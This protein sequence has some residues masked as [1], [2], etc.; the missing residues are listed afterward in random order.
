MSS[1]VVAAALFV[2]SLLPSMAAP[3]ADDVLGAEPA[4]VSYLPLDTDILNP[5]R[6]L[7]VQVDLVNETNL[8]WVREQGSVIAFAY[9]RLDDYRNSAIPD[10]FLI[11]LSRG[12]DA[13]RAAGIKIIFR[14]TYNF[15]IGE[16]DAPQDRVLQHISQIQP[17]FEQ[18]QDVIAVVQAGFIGAWGEWH[19]STNGLNEPAVELEIRDALLA[20]VPDTRM[21]QFRYLRDIEA[22]S[23]TPLDE[24]AAYSATPQARTAHH[25]DCF[26][27]TDDDAGTYSPGSVVDH[28]QYLEVASQFLVIGGE[29]C[30][31]EFDTNLA[32]RSCTVAREE[33]ARFHWSYLHEFFHMPTLQIWK[34]QGCWDEITQRL[35]YRYRLETS[36]LPQQVLAG[37]TLTGDVTIANDGYATLFNPRPVYLVLNGPTRV[38]FQLDADPRRWAAGENTTLALAEQLP[39]CLPTGTYTIALWLPDASDSLRNRPDYAVRMANEGVWNE[40]SGYNVLGEVAVPPGPAGA[41]FADDDGSVFEADIEWLAEQGI[42]KGCNPPAN[43]LFC[44]DDVVTRGQLAAFL[45]RA[46]GYTDDGGGN[47]FVDDDNSIFEG[48]IDRLGTAGVTRGCNPPVNNRYCPDDVVTRGQMAAFLVRALRYTDDG[49]GNLFIDDDGSVFEGDIDRLGTAGVTKGCNPPTNDRFCP[50]SAV[51]RGQMAAFLHRALG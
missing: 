47:L 39:G 33:T 18:H 17:L 5:E 9:V 27:S 43:D 6:G 24:G 46:L 26:L 7:Y 10:T 36:R 48:D 42:T 29:T 51:T 11:N 8:Q 44:P 30:Q 20:A 3:V 31:V 22:W 15:G 4:A 2:M 34:D 1:A 37:A 32:R 45:V 50:D 49:G 28:K 21:V 16:E 35:G 19:S 12:F 40:T 38:E 23:P 13:A 25:N 41:C 14:A